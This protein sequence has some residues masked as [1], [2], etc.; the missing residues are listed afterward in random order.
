MQYNLLQ[1]GG[2]VL[3]FWLLSA[4]LCLAAEPSSFGG[5]LVVANKGDRSMGIIDPASG[6][7][8]ATVPEGGVTGHEVVASPDGRTAYVPI[9]GDSGVGQPGSD[10]RNM[11]AVDI[12]SR[13][14]TGSVDFG[15][16]VRPHCPVIGP[17]NGL[18]YVTT[19]L[20]HS[21]TIVDPRTL[22]IVGAVPTGQP[23]SH[24]LAIASD[25]RRGYTSNVGPGTVSVLDL[26]A[27]KVLGVIPISKTTQRISISVDDRLVFTADQTSPRLAVIDAAAQK[28]THWISL[29]APGYGAAPTRDGRWLLVAVP[30]ANQVAVVD[31]MTMQVARAIDVPSAPQEVLIRPDDQVAYVSCD[32]SGQVAEIGLSNWKVNRLIHAGRGAD[33]LAWSASR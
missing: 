28:V 15:H 18:L 23:E 22:K 12:A 11:V 8:V 17:V 20:D 4:V 9:Y 13:K 19:E 3:H 16:G 29:P 25:G 21:I 6:L 10:G 31:L 27:K 33:G 7:L 24:M 5:F 32:A 14:V 1:Y 30:Q 26:E 2:D